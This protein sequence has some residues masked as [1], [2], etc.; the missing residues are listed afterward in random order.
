M[1]LTTVVPINIKIF[2]QAIL[3]A[4][5]F[6]FA[7]CFRT[8]DDGLDKALQMAGT[9]RPELEAVLEHFRDDSLKLEAARFLIRNMTYYYSMEEY[10]L[11]PDGEK[12]RPDITLFENTKK[13][14]EHCDSLIR[15]GYR[16]MQHKHSDITSL[17][18][19]YLIENIELAFSVW[20]KIWAKDIQFFDFCR[21]IL[22]YKAQIEAPST[23]RKEMMERFMPVLDYANVSTPLEVCMI[24]NDC[25]NNIMRYED[26]GLSFYPTIEETYRSG[27]SR[28]EGLC[29]LGTFIMRAVGIPVTVDFTIWVK[30]DLGHSWCAVN[31]KIK[32]TCPIH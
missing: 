24:T 19:Q 12:Q 8:N 16:P 3:F 32:K 9:N 21:Y 10:Y 30:M 15:N 23:L 22:P 29:N 17:N 27:I 14:H 25:L 26:R 6:I 1:K 11:S 4:H 13:V 18:H 31:E 5:L 20:Q 7:S 28:C 2:V